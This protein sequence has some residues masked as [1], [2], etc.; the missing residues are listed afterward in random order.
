MTTPS[1]AAMRAAEALRKPKHEGR[2]RPAGDYERLR[3]TCAK[4]ADER[5][6]LRAA[7]QLARGTILGL[8]DQQ[9]MPDD[10]WETGV[11]AIDAALKQP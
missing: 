8:V 3:D 11:A 10:W 9:A 7:L 5:D 2:E 6:R 1:E 4:I